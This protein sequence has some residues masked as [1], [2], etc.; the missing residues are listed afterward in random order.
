[1]KLERIYTVPLGE[2]YETV[3]QKRVPR[4]VKILR[5]FVERHMKAKGLKI[6]LST[7]INEHLWEHSIQRPP[8]RV[9]VRLIKEDDTVRAYLADEKPAEP[10]KTE[11]KKDEK[12]AEEKKAAPKEEQKK[13]PEKA[14]EKKPATQPAKTEAHNIRSI[15][16]QSSQKSG[17][18]K[19]QQNPAPVQHPAQHGSQTPGG[20]K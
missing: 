20:K 7:A 14:P 16:P 3:R 15:P 8:R 10:K 4:A 1:M 17:E 5:A 6:I 19:P 2:A 18:H 13:A 9:K 12:K 11:A